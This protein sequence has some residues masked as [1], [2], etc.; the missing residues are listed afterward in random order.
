[1]NSKPCPENPKLRTPAYREE[2]ILPLRT[3]YYPG[4]V[5][6]SW[7]LPRYQEIHLSPSG[8]REVLLR[9]GLNRLPQNAKKR[10]VLTTR[11]EKQVPGPHVPVDVKFLDGLRRKAKPSVVFNTP[12]WMMPRGSVLCR[13]RKSTQAHAI[14]FLHYVVERF[15]FRIHTVR[16]DHGHEFQAKF[17]GH[18]EDLGMTHS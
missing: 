4:Q 7:Y 18:V 17:H 5:R 16:T 15:P 12:P 14:S 2:K 3:T 6:I 1:M 13:S 11:S 9:H 10:T 8:V